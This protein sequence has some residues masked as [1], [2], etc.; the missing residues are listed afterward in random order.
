MSTT[1]PTLPRRVDP[2]YRLTESEW[3]DAAAMQALSAAVR[4]V[5]EQLPG[6]ERA[7]VVAEALAHLELGAL[8]WCA[9]CRAARPEGFCFDH[10]IG[11]GLVD[12]FRRHAYA[13]LP[14]RP[15]IDLDMA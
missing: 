12:A 9:D 3:M 15:L 8:E 13:R 11:S 10:I 5:V 2:D 7:V 4:G 1:I 14:G 6:P